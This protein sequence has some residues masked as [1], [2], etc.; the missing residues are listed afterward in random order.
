[1]V[2]SLPADGWE[3][4]LE[5]EMAT[6]SSIFAWKIPWTIPWKIPCGLQSMESQE[7]RTQLERLSTQHVKDFIRQSHMIIWRK[8]AFIIPPVFCLM[9]NSIISIPTTRFSSFILVIFSFFFLSV[10]R[11]LNFV[12]LYCVF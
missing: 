4:P 5:E 8:I 3:A 11:L 9:F 10:T 1:M 6:H 7:S 12:F 2:N